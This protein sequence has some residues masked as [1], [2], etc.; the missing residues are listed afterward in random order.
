MKYTFVYILSILSLGFSCSGGRELKTGIKKQSGYLISIEGEELVFLPSNSPKR[1]IILEELQKDTGYRIKG[2]NSGNLE[3][4]K[5]IG[6]RFDVTIPLIDT[7]NNTTS[8]VS[9]QMIIVASRLKFHQSTQGL[10]PIR[11]SGIPFEY[12]GKSYLYYFTIDLDKSIIEVT[13]FFRE[14]RRLLQ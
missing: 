11:N 12:N 8:K 10:P 7:K 5:S 3:K 13:P 9:Y 1:K 4:L 6:Q 14:D 2:F